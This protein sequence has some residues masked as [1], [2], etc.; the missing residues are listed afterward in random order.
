MQAIFHSF[1][2]HTVDW[3]LLVCFFSVYAP[4]YYML[5][6]HS[7][8]K[9][10]NSYGW[11]VLLIVGY[12]FWQKKHLLVQKIHFYKIHWPACIIFVIGILMF[13]IGY[14]QSIQAL[15]VG[16]QIPVMTAL[17]V[18]FKGSKIAKA[19]WFP[20]F[21]IAF[22]VPM[23][24]QFLD[25]VTLPLKIAVSY[26]AEWILYYA[27]Y[28]I[29]RSG[30][31]LQI[32]NY[33]LLVADACAGMKTLMSLEAMGLLYLNIVQ[34]DSWQRNLMLGLLIIPISFI[35]NVTR[36]VILALITFHFGDA[37]GQGFMHKFAGLVLFMVALLL[38]MSIDTL[39]Q[40]RVKT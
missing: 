6:L 36:V 15:A 31:I 23:P 26:V 11:L 22:I 35:A 40:K 5:F 21:F 33:Q 29:G 27:E 1:R 17:L 14:S 20:L 37:A 39:I 16:S 25:L 9:E 28:P 12:L 13:V 34:H 32:G 10:E 8:S 2:S 30:V 38:I 24:A 4:V 3:V 7:W 19:C 18:Q